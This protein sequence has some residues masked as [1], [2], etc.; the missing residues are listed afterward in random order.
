MRVLPNQERMTHAF[1]WAANVL[2]KNALTMVI[3]DVLLKVKHNT[4]Y[5]T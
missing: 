4:K 1:K 2:E 5:Y 3:N